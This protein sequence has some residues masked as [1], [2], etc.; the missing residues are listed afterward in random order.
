MGFSE[1]SG[2]SVEYEPVTYR[3]GLSFK[4]GLMIIPGKIKPIR[5]T[6]K[7]GLTN[8]SYLHDWIEKSQKEL[9]GAKRDVIIELCDQKCNPVITWTAQE[10]MPIKLEISPF[11]A[12]SNTVAVASL[13]LVVANL[14]V[15]YPTK[16]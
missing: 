16:I 12:S 14:N 8:S 13:E 15:N 11:I 5:L 7:K 3:H 10:S 4:L 9:N 1:V 2:L 6:L